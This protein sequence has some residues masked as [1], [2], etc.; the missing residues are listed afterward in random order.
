M[1]TPWK[2]CV[3]LFFT[4]VLAAE[5]FVSRAEARPVQSSY[6]QAQS[7]FARGAFEEAIS[8]WL[9][10]AELYALGRPFG[11]SGPDPGS[12]GGGVSEPG[13]VWGRSQGA[14]KRPDF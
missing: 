10:A 4:T 8:G 11:R 13:S 6:E 9:E 3:L 12:S 14:G 1:H 7:A 5:P 2:V